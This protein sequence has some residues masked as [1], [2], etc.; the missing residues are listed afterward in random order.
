MTEGMP[1]HR[2]IDCAD[3]VPALAAL[4]ARAPWIAIDCEANSMFV[5]RERCCLIQFN[6]GGELAVVDAFKLLQDDGWDGSRASGCLAPLRD[7]LGRSDRTLWLHGGEYDAAILRRDFDLELGGVF[8]TQQ[9][10]GLLG[11]AETGYGALVERCCGVHLAKEYAQYDW[12]T[13]PLD[14]AALAYALDDVAHLPQVGEHLRQAIRDADLEEEQEIAS[15]A[16]ASTIWNGGFDPGGFWRV[17]GI[18]EL[19]RHSLPV[20]GAL[21]AWRDAVARTENKPPGRVVNNQLLLQLARNTPTSFGH[22]KHNGVK[23]WVLAQHGEALIACLRQAR[24]HPPSLPPRPNHREVDE[25][26]ERREKRLKDWRR[27]EAERRK[28]PLQVV[29]PAKALEFLKR[30]GAGDL[31]TAPQLGPKR[32]ARY[33]EKLRELCS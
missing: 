18:R 14:P 15:Q 22:L 21:W 28:V 24:E 2:W 11:W 32:I 17:K 5:Y 27:S 6:A 26:E 33:G 12:G 23:G 4:L 3:D 9:A 1:P 10:A 13:R 31:A 29:L 7:Q 25:A 8:D 20:L 30:Y 19:P 16:V